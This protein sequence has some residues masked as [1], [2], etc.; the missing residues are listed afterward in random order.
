MAIRT[1]I[2]TQD[3]SG[4]AQAA[5]R[6]VVFGLQDNEHAV[7]AEAV[8]EVLRMVALTPLPE[9]P[10]WLPG[11]INLRGRVVPVIDLRRR[12]GLPEMAYGLNTPILVVEVDGRIMGLVPDTVV[13]IL[14][15]PLD[16][17]DTPDGD[18]GPMEG[19]ARAGDRLIVIL[20]LPRLCEGV[21]EF[22]PPDR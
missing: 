8:V 16:A 11:V 12:L 4:G 7:P 2:E 3:G 6:L 13:E 22:A 15:V 10:D 20:D 21:A 5:R 1:D 14:S 18:A 9:G 17:V 19:L